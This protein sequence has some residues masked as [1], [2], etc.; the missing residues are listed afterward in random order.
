MK[1]ARAT[2]FAAA[3]WPATPGGGSLPPRWPMPRFRRPSRSRRQD[4]GKNYF[5]V[6]GLESESGAAMTRKLSRAKVL[7]LFAGLAPCRVGM[8][9]CG[10]AHYW[11]RELAALGHEPVLIAPAYV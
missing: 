6:H 9:A 11:A 3:R 7:G 1:P 5:Q 10:S 2:L 4:L 8:E